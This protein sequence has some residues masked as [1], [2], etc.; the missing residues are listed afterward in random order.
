MEEELTE[1]LQVRIKG[2][3]GISDIV[4]GVFYRPPD[5]EDRADKAH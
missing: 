4:V 3:T 5:E 2:R 1:S